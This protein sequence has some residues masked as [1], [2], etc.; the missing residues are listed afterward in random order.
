[1]PEPTAATYRF[2]SWLRQGLLAGLSNNAAASP[3]AAAGHLVL[4]IRLRV[5]SAAPSI[6]TSS[7]MVPAT[8]PASMRARSSARNRMRR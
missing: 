7:S 5:N 3:P 1:M 6:S 4:P 2:F 8:S